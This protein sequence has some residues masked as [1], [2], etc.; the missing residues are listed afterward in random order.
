M[1]H[2][3]GKVFQQPLRSGLHQGR[4]EQGTQGQPGQEVH[5]LV[6]VPAADL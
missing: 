1:A 6:R 5:G 2:Q 4:A 3:A